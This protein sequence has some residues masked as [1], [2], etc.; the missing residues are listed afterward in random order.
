MGLFR[1]LFWISSIV[2]FVDIMRYNNIWMFLGNSI[3]FFLSI[4]VLRSLYYRPKPVDGSSLFSKIKDEN[5][6]R[7]SIKSIRKRIS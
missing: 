3:A 5:N 4:G 2:L 1:I 7:R 6:S